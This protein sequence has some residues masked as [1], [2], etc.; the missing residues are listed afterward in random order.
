MYILIYIQGGWGFNRYQTIVSTGLVLSY[1]SLQHQYT[2]QL[3]SF[4]KTAGIITFFINLTGPP[5]PNL[6]AVLRVKHA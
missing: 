2:N 1:L 5:F 4:L 6:K 3:L